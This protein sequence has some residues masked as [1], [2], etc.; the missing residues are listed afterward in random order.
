MFKN[1]FI[2]YGMNC[3]NNIL[4]YTLTG[5][6]I[7]SFFGLII[8][9]ML[10]FRQMSHCVYFYFQCFCMCLYM[11][12]FISYLF[13]KINSQKIFEIYDELQAYCA[14]YKI[15]Q[16]NKSIAIYLILHSIYY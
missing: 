16:D 5:F 8:H 10:S 12:T 7:T 2:I 14:K 3:P 11:S 9:T 4:N 13:V 15:Y 6:I 1:L